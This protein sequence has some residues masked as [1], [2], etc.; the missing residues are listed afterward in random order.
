MLTIQHKE[1]SGFPT[2]WSISLSLTHTH[3]HTHTHIHFIHPK[4]LLN[5]SQMCNKSQCTTHKKS[6]HAQHK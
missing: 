6:T 2:P 4:D 5:N 1:Y 3:T